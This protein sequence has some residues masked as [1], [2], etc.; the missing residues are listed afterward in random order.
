MGTSTEWPLVSAFTVFANAES[1]QAAKK[2]NTVSGDLT[3]L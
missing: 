2:N 1:T 3:A